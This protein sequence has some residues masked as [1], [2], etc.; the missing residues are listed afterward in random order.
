MK[1]PKPVA[2][3]LVVTWLTVLVVAAFGVT[4]YRGFSADAIIMLLVVICVVCFFA[5]IAIL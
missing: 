5:L 3:S 1:Y 4:W 2:I